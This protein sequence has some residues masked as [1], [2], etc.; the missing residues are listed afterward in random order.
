MDEE[1][2]TEQS[3]HRGSWLTLWWVPLITI[4]IYVLS[5]GPAVRFL[6]GDSPVFNLYLPLVALAEKCSP[7]GEFLGWYLD[8]IWGVTVRVSL[9]S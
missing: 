1:G 6:P 4:L 5:L 7:F 3:R 8:Q 2:K 9:G